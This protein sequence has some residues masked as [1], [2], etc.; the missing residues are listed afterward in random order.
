MY[1][2][3]FTAI[4]LLVTIAVLG[5]LLALAIPSFVEFTRASRGSTLSS[6]FVAGM[7]R[8]R[9]EAISQNVCVKIC[10]SANVNTVSNAASAT[11][12]ATGDD[13]QRGWIIFKVPD[14][15]TTLSDPVDSDVLAVRLGEQP[16]YRLFSS[17]SAVRTFLFEPRGV[18]IS[19]NASNLTLSYLPQGT[20]SKHARTI[21]VSFAG[22]VTVRE[23]GLGCSG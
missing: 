20:S 16:D 1:T 3:G 15:D 21:C 22:R 6:S 14:C 12:E 5:V 2:S 13:W 7:S 4:E 18:L 8:A 19:G 10:Q 11:C 23:W 9:S 17:G